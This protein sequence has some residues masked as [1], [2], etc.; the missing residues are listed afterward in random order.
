[1]ACSIEMQFCER[2][3]RE[4]PAYFIHVVETE[5]EERQF[6]CAECVSETEAE[7]VPAT[8]QPNCA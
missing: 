3:G 4:V 6:I 1:M 2:C 7:P 5:D 8:Q